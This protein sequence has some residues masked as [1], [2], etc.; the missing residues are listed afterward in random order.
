MNSFCLK[1]SPLFSSSLLSRNTL[2][3]ILSS[4]NFACILL[5]N[6]ETIGYF[7]FENWN[8]REKLEK[9]QEVDPQKDGMRDVRKVSEFK[10][11]LTSI[12]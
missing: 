2:F 12:L 3:W 5:F 1:P 10:I 7:N 8:W 4:N 11:H 6:E 9:I